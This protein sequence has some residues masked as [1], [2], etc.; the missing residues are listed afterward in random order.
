MIVWVHKLKTQRENIKCQLT[1]VNHIY[2]ISTNHIQ[3]CLSLSSQL[4]HV[5]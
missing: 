2:F 5:K 1:I 4:S 3:L